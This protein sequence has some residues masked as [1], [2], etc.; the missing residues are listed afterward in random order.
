MT[1]TVFLVVLLAALLHATWNALVRSAVDPTTSMAAVVLGQAIFGALCLPIFPPP[2]PE[3][4]SLLAVGVAL[5]LG[6]Q[7]L[8]IEAYKTGGL[9]E[10]YPLARGSAPLLVAVVSVLFLG[11]TLSVL[12]LA[13]VVLISCGLVSLVVVGAGGLY[14][15]PAPATV[16]ALCTGAFIASY[17]LIDGYGAQLSVSPVA[18]FAWL[19][20]INTAALFAIVPLWNPAAIRAV[21]AAWRV[22]LIGGFASF[23]AYALVVW[24][25]TQAPIATVTALR[26]TS[27]LFAI[28]IGVVFLNEKLDVRRVLAA[29]LTLVGAA[30]LRLGRTG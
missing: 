5:H 27:I 30:A 22:V 7:F 12:E 6:Y 28:A 15:L 9:S 3:S 4:W 29:F 17:S 21:P 11:V 18:F 2:A 19:A 8:L 10:V 16:M 14:K 20:V 25:F 13:G 24:A 23:T 1:L 26:E